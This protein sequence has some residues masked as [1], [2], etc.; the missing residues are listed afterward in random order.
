MGDKALRQWRRKY[1][2]DDFHDDPAGAFGTATAEYE[3]GQ[4]WI[5]TQSGAAWSV[6]DLDD[7]SGSSPL[8]CFE[9]VAEQDPAW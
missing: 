7:G 2:W 1:D 8:F 3:H 4:W 6:N 5:V 9:Q